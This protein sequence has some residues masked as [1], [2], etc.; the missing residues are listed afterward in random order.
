M[1]HM[2]MIAEQVN[3]QVNK[4][5]RKTFSFSIFGLCILFCVIVCKWITI[6]LLENKSFVLFCKEEN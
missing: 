3:F 2:L 1:H 5:T 4:R 6:L